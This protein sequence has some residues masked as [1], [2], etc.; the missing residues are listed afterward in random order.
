ML[1]RKHT[2]GIVAAVAVL[3]LGSGVA[4]AIMSGANQEPD[5]A[6]STSASIQPASGAA[7]ATDRVVPDP[8]AQRASATQQQQQAACDDG[9]IVGTVAGG[10]AGG[11]VGSQFGKG[12][13]KTATTIGGALGG[14]ALGNQFIPTRNVTCQ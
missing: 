8:D 6:A 1:K 12:N 11:V 10:V 7:V 13:G 5:N 3:L 4:F 9:N 2:I 14:A